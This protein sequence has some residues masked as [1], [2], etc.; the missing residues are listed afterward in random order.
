[1]AG[2]LT[3]RGELIIFGVGPRGVSQLTLEALEALKRCDE[4]FGTVHQEA[5]ARFCRGFGLKYTGFDWGGVYGAKRRKVPAGQVAGAVLRGL[6]RGRRIGVAVTGSPALFSLADELIGRCRGKGHP[7]RVF[8]SVGSL[9]QVLVA[10]KFRFGDTFADGFAVYNVESV[11]PSAMT[12]GPG[13][14]VLLYNMG[15]LRRHSPVRF[16]R[17]RDRL[18]KAYGRDGKAFLVECSPEEDAILASSPG[19]LETDLSRVGINATVCLPAE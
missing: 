5:L 18:K 17:L 14:S 16:R 7:C 4:V 11:Q 2:A 1:M 12:L 10:L 8:A 3:M 13:F 19:R 6:S 15:S 9:E